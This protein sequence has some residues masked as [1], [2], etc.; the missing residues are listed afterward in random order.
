MPV[1]F[2]SILKNIPAPSGDANAPLQML[3][4][5]IIGDNFK[6]RIAIGKIYNGIMKE[7]QTITHIN[8]AGEQKKIRLMSLMTFS[9]LSKVEAKEVAAGDIAAIAGIPDINIGETIADPI[10]PQA[11]PLLNIDEPTVKMIF[12]INDSPSAGKEGKFSTSRQIRERLMRELETEMA[13]HARTLFLR[14]SKRLEPGSAPIVKETNLRCSTT[15]RN[16]SASNVSSPILSSY[17]A[18]ALWI[19]FRSSHVPSASIS[20]ARIV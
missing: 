10:S 19:S 6:G 16:S 1:Y 7:G 17:I 15:G 13:L 8:R 14:L 20:I 3:V 18:G 4:T 11:L 12:M 2:E 5:S 9:G